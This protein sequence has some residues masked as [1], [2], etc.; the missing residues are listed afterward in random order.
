MNYET[1]Q[2]QEKITAG[3]RARTSNSDP[4][5]PKIIGSLWEKF[6]EGGVFDSIPCKNAAGIYGIYTN[7]D[8]DV[9][10]KYD[11]AV[12]CGVSQCKELPEGVSIQ[13]IPAGK[14]AKFT[15]SGEPKTA[16]AKAWEEIWKVKLDRKHLCDFEEY[17]DDGTINIYIGLK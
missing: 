8:S 7:Y 14:Y 2:L 1:V 3:I 10:G 5:M 4:E 9:N 11:I 16:T 13:K 6:F 12:S 15:V 17:T